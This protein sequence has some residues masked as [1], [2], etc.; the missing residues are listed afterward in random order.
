MSFRRVFPLARR[1]IQQLL[2]DRRTLVLIFLVPLVVLTVAGVLV[3]L[4]PDEIRLGVVMEDEGAALPVGGGGDAV[5]LGERLTDSLGTL[6]ENLSVQQLDAAEAQSRI[7]DGKLD[8]IITLPADFTA[9]TIQNRAVTLDV[10][11]EGSNP[12]VAQMFDTL[13]N[14]A[15]VQAIASLSA[16]STGSTP[17]VTVQATYLYGSAEF[18]QLDYLAPAFIGLFVFMFVFIL[19]SVAFLRERVA[20][21][22][23]RLQATPIRQIEIIVGYMC[24]FAVFAL[25]QALIIL[26]YTIYGLNVHYMGSLLVVFVVELLLALMAVNLGVFFSTFARNEF[27]VVQFIPL[28]VVTQVF[29]SGALWAVEDMPGWLQPI[30]WLMPLTYANYAL[31]DVMIKGFDLIQVGGYVLALVGFA[32]AFVLLSAQTIRRQAVG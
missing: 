32:A 8:A 12:K 28:V 1:V 21:T 23:E 18:D 13:L 17:D 26:I 7:E 22:L 14:R 6:T 30:A 25:V 10:E 31:R 24:G 20:G 27:Q 16:V 4:E 11:Y 2:A 15:A 3:R 29:L 19:T 9:Q 5:N